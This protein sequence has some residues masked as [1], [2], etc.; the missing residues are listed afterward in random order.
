MEL[1]Y[2][3]I[4]VAAILI[5]SSA[6]EHVHPSSG[7]ARIVLV[8]AAPWWVWFTTAVCA[9]RFPMTD[10]PQR[11]LLLF[12]MPV[13]V[14][15]AMEDDVPPVTRRQSLTRPSPI[16]CEVAGQGVVDRSHRRSLSPC[17]VEG[18]RGV[19]IPLTGLRTV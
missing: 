6:A 1:F 19:P 4:F 13:I 17:V 15:M 8:F 11:I 12:Q 16:H 9:N 5:F 10:V 14:L 3:V 7:I 2:D 18:W